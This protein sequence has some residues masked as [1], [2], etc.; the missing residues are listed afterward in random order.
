MDVKFSYSRTFFVICHF[1][2]WFNFLEALTTSIRPWLLLWI[3]FVK[4]PIEKNG[5]TFGQAIS[6]YNN[7]M[8]TLYKLSFLLNK[9][10]F[11]R[12]DLLK[13][14]ILA[15]W[16][17]L[18]GTNYFKK[19]PFWFKIANFCQFL[20]NFQS[21][22]HLMW[23]VIIFSL[24]LIKLIQIDQFPNNHQLSTFVVTS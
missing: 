13:V 5:T 6:D 10:S 16:Y 20:Y 8:I 24:N 21:K 17:P 18:S 3:I 7:P 23:L 4:V 15:N 1:L 19:G 9:A 11:R 12:W 14:M 22:S 2:H